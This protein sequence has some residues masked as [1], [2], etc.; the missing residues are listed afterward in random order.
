MDFLAERRRHAG[1]SLRTA[2]TALHALNRPW[3]RQ[4]LSLAGSLSEQLTRKYRPLN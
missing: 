3:W 4:W 2:R 1:V